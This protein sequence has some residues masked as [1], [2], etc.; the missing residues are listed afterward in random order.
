MP[1]AVHTSQLPDVVEGIENTIS[2]L[3]GV[4]VAETVL[5]L[6]VD[7]ELRQTKDLTHEME[8]NSGRRDG[9]LRPALCL[10]LLVRLLQ[11]D[12]VFIE[13][14]TSLSIFLERGR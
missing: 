7:N 6:S 5:D 2:K 11:R 14:N 9:G 13:Q 10:F 1:G 8:C 4:D 3:E 12:D